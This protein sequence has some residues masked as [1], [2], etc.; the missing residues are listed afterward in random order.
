MDDSQY[1]R[2]HEPGRRSANSARTQSQGLPTR[3]IASRHGRHRPHLSPATAEAEA[4]VVV[5]HP[6]LIASRV[7]ESP[8]GRMDLRDQ[9]RARPER[10]ARSRSE[11]TGA[12]MTQGVRPPSGRVSRYSSPGVES[13][14]SSRPTPSQEHPSR[15]AEHGSGRH[16]GRGDQGQTIQSRP[17]CLPASSIRTSPAPCRREECRPARP[18][19]RRTRSP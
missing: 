13:A 2:R 8:R 16:R 11:T 18:R 19:R 17:A 7:G 4:R 9:R 3:S 1:P 14:S 15:D 10:T 12:S 6:R 5:E